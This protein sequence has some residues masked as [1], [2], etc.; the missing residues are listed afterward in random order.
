MVLA[1]VCAVVHPVKVNLGGG[2]VGF[3]EGIGERIAA[4]R[5]AQNP[6]AARDEGIALPARSCVQYLHPGDLF[7]LREPL[8][9]YASFKLPW[10]SA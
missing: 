8:D 3:L 7:G 1:D 5:D 6:P 4:C 10:I 9:F 2:L